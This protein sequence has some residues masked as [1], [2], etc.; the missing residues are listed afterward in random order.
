MTVGLADHLIPALKAKIEIRGTA[1]L[2]WGSLSSF[3][4]ASLNIP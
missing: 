4:I 2:R 1:T 3:A